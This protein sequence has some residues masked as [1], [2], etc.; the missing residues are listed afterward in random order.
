MPDLF[1]T[2]GHEHRSAHISE[3]GRYRWSLRRSWQI[4]EN[5]LHVRGKGVC[6]FVMLNPSTADALQNDP[7]ISRCIGFARLWGYDTLSVRNLFAYRATDPKAL[8]TAENPT[9]G[10]FG[11][12]ELLCAATANLLVVAW[13][14]SVPFGRESEALSL[15]AKHAPGKTLYCL[16]TTQRGHPRHPL[17]VKADTQ[18]IVF[19]AA[20]VPET[21]PLAY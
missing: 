13:G 9:G 1:N 14:A 12:A 2:A 21:I 18:P 4:W 20:A 15:F 3:C 7:T 19:R 11:D 17:Y 16:G 8:L 5:G 6:C 10:H